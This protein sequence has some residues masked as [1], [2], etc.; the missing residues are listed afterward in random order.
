MTITLTDV[1]VQAGNVETFDELRALLP[2]SVSPEDDVALD[3]HRRRIGYQG[4]NSIQ[5]RAAV[6]AAGSVEEVKEMWSAWADRGHSEEGILSMLCTE[7]RGE[8]GE[9]LTEEMV[10]MVE[11][12]RKA[13]RQGAKEPPISGSFDPRGRG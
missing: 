4:L 7:R 12:I 6:L 10:E 5:K 8:L 9:E 13:A 1:Y 11:R 2:D 3:A